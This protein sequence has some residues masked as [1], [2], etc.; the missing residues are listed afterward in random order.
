MELSPEDLE[1]DA[2][3]VTDLSGRT[4]RSVRVTHVPTGTVVM[5]DDSDSQ[6]ENKARALAQLSDLLDRHPD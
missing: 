4:Q 1:I 5:V 6:S 2:Y 3:A